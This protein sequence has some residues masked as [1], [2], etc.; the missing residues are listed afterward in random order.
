MAGEKGGICGGIIL[1]LGVCGA[2]VNGAPG[3]D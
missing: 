3:W 1:N 2:V